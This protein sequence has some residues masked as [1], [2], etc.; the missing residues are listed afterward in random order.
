MTDVPQLRDIDQTILH[1]IQ[2]GHNDTQKITS[3]TTIKTHR[4]RYSLKKLQQQGLITVEQPD[5]MVERVIDGQ[6][7]VFQ[8]PKKAELTDKG[9]QKTEELNQE[10]LEAFKNMSHRELVK[11]TRRLEKDINELENAFEAFRKQV[12]Q[13][14]S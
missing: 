11:K 14:I 5:Q 4:V 1:H 12:Q 9:L 8:H 2:N 6:K 7:R 13:K 10:N 3:K